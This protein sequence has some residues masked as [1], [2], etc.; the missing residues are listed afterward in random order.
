MSEYQSNIG[1]LM[2]QVKELKDENLKLNTDIRVIRNEHSE[3]AHTVY[4]LEQ[5]NLGLVKENEGLKHQ[6]GRLEIPRPPTDLPRQRTFQQ[7]IESPFNTVLN[8]RQNHE[9]TGAFPTI[10]N[11]VKEISHEPQSPQRI[12]T[13]QS[14]E[15]E[16]NEE[17]LSDWVL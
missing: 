7:I 14:P 16:A 11:S 2:R 10:H 17:E 3:M 9:G 1:G 8:K 6:L 4:K 12:L 5:K 15:S 13:F